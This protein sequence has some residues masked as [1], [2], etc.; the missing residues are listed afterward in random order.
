[1][2]ARWTA[3][4]AED[5]CMDL[6]SQPPLPLPPRRSTTTASSQLSR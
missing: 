6:A 3:E 1:M 5:P 4:V 2:E